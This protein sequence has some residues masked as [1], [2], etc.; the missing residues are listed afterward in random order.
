VPLGMALT[1]WIP[2]DGQLG[3]LRVETLSQY[4]LTTINSPVQRAIG[5]GIGLGM[6]AMALRIWLSL[7]RGTYFEESD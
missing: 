1:S 2:A 3:I 4:I 7:E 5:F 6:L